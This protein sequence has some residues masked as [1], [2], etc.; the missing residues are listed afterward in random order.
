[1]DLEERREDLLRRIHTSLKL[2]I[3]SAG[4]A[5]SGIVLEDSSAL[6]HFCMAI[7]GV[8]RFGMKGTHAT[9]T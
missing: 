9:Y 8:L 4:K 5:G 2:I 7:E 3:S 1:M 6:D